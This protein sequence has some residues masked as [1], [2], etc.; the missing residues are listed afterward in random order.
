MHGSIRNDELVFKTSVVASSISRSC[1][2]NNFKATLY[3]PFSTI[4]NTEMLIK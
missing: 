1:F 2:L 3:Q 4:S